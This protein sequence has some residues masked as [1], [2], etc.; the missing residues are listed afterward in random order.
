MFPRNFATRALSLCSVLMAAGV[1]TDAAAAE[2]LAD[3][4]VAKGMTCESCHAETPPS[5]S[6]KTEKCLECHG[7]LEKIGEQYDAAKAGNLP[8]P[9]VNHNSELYCEDCHRGHS[10]G[11][12]YCAQCHD[13]VYKIP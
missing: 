4:H 8:N 9:H 13:F 11:V 5:K 10:Q 12:N 2:M 7:S 1:M 6:V 3:R